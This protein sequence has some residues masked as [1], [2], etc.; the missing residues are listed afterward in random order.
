LEDGDS[1]NMPLG[2]SKNFQPKTTCPIF[3]PPGNIR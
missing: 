3:M 1:A 2:K